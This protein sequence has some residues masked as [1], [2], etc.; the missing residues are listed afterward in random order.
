MDRI[1]NYRNCAMAAMTDP[2]ADAISVSQ[3]AKQLCLEMLQISSVANINTIHVCAMAHS[4]TK[5]WATA[6]AAL[7]KSQHEH[8]Q[9]RKDVEECMTQLMRRLQ[10]LL[11]QLTARQASSVLT[12]LSTNKMPVTEHLQGLAVKLTQKLATGD[13]I[14]RDIAEALSTLAQWDTRISHDPTQAAAT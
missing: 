6:S 9:R 5:M 3:S 7:A 12:Y 11:P 4:V 13:A 10:P 8:W 14:A 1:M 2:K